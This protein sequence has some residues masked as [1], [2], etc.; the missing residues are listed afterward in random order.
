MR[1]FRAAV[2]PTFRSGAARSVRL[3]PDEHRAAG[4][5]LAALFFA[6]K[7]GSQTQRLAAGVRVATLLEREGCRM[8]VKVL[9]HF[10]AALSGWALISPIGDLRP[11]SFRI[12][13]VHLAS[14][15]SGRTCSTSMLLIECRNEVARS[16]SSRV[17]GAKV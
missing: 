17:S 2:G 12:S 16:S 1:P 7:V 14:I 13:S 5:G 9:A 4:L 15:A 8:A 10:G 3:Q 6:A 11:R